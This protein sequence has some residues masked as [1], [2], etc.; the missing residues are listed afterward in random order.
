MLRTAEEGRGASFYQVRLALKI[1]NSFY[2]RKHA[3]RQK[4]HGY[5]IPV[6]IE[7]EYFNA[8]ESRS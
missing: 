5:F 4:L 2:L 3:Y 8:A 1:V 6:S 7:T